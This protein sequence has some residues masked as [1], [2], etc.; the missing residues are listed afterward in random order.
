M[1]IAF[2][3]SWLQET[4]E[5]SGTAKSIGGLDMA[6][7]ACGHKVTRIAPFSAWPQTLTLRRLLFNLQLPALL[8]RLDY[9]LIVG[10]D[11]D[12]VLWAGQPAS[13]PYI[14]CVKGVIAEE[15]QHERGRVRLLFRLLAQLERI[16][17]RRATLVLTDSA[18]GRSAIGRHYGVPAAK[19]R[20][21]PAGIDL[22]RWRQLVVAAPYTGDG[23][24]IL[25]VARQYP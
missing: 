21:V 7:A 22:A 23:A 1:R 14:A 9:D 19:V 16:N 17:V 20:L 10:F 15:L 12:G 24:T 4:V 18:Y 5:G 13:T 2:L 6:L 25:C 11:I 3:D 8:R